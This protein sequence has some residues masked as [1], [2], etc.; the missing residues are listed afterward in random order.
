[1][2]LQAVTLTVMFTGQ[3]GSKHGVTKCCQMKL[4]QR[5]PPGIDSGIGGRKPDIGRVGK[6]HHR[7]LCKL[8]G[9]SGTPLMQQAAHHLQIPWCGMRRSKMPGLRDMLVAWRLSGLRR[10]RR[11]TDEKEQ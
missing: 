11:Q 10:H 1:M 8:V 6:P 3:A 4:G 2:R 5:A 7:N 9:F